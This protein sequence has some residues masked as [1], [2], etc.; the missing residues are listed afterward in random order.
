MRKNNR[1]ERASSSLGTAIVIALDSSLC[2]EDGFF[3]DCRE[4]VGVG[5]ETDISTSPRNGCSLK[6]NN[7]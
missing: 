4:G 1:F 7:R 2:Y 3:G 6:N 5:G